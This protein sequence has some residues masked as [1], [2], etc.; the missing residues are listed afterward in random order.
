V[1]ILDGGQLCLQVV[2]VMPMRNKSKLF[3]VLF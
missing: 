2:V 3:S 1:R